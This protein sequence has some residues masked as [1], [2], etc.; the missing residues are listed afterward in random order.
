[1]KTAIAVTMMIA[2]HPTVSKRRPQPTV[3]CPIYQGRSALFPQPKKS[4]WDC[5][6]ALSQQAWV[7][8]NDCADFPDIRNGSDANPWRQKARSSATDQ[9]AND[10][11]AAVE[12][13]RA[14]LPSRHLTP[15]GTN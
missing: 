6:I 3:L 1:M 11:L 7:L 8:G 15:A 4:L 9:L 12:P 2:I 10:R 13:F 5:R 14:V